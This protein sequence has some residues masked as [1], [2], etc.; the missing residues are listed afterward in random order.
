MWQDIK[1]IYHLFIAF[2]SNVIFL[3]PSRKLRVIG[4]TG[5]DG[6]TT[7]V[8]LIYHILKSANKNVS[9]LSSIEALIN[10]KSYDTGFH[11]TTPSPFAL[12]K[13][14]KKAKDSGSQYFILEVTSHALDQNRV[15]GIPFEIG[16]LTNITNEHLDYHKTYGEYLNVKSKLLIG[17]KIAV[18]N[19]DDGAF[20][21][22]SKILSGRNVVTYGRTRNSE[23]N[24][25]DFKF[26]F[27]KE[28]EFNIYNTL[29]AVSVCRALGITDTFIKNA[30]K[31]FKIP[32]G[33]LDVVYDSDFEVVIDFAH[34]PNAFEE[35]LSHLRKKISGKII[36]VFG[37]AGE[38]D[39]TKRPEMGKISDKYSGL[40]ILTSED[41]RSEN[42]LAIIEDIKKE[43]KNKGKIK[44]II[45][46]REAIN[47][48]IKNAK[49][50]DLVLITGKAHERSMNMGHGE[51]PW[52][53]YN[54]VKE[55]L[56]KYEN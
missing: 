32:K 42:P 6:K 12:Q 48:A 16:V 35:V 31:N 13:F 54:V 14:L 26:N 24:P 21:E 51:E 52:D 25:T 49:K 29:A 56:G 1:N 47:Y 33:R 41:P 17:S 22:I 5:T 34:T 27:S 39:K 11:V 20:R 15:F 9:M 37:A 19:S 18:V 45:D 3:W 43:I 36:H 44:S 10:N 30:L 40:I 55:A 28:S 7:T 2:F 4:V 53:E 38:R 8:H 46:R 50:G 23:I